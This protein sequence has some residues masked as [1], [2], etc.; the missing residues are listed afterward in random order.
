[1]GREHSKDKG[2]DGKITL[3]WNVRER[4]CQIDS[5]GSRLGPMAEDSCVYG[6]EPSVSIK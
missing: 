4:G 3:K 5:S 6:Y 1:M 2:D